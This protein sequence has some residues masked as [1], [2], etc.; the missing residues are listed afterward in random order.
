[1]TTKECCLWYICDINE[2]TVSQERIIK[3]LQELHD[4]TY[5]CLYSLQNALPTAELST[6]LILHIILKKLDTESYK[7][8]E[9]GLQNPKT[10]QELTPFLEFLSAR[11]VH[12]EAIEDNARREEPIKSETNS[13]SNK[14]NFDKKNYEKR[15]NWSKCSICDEEHETKNCKVFNQLTLQ[16]R[17][18]KVKSERICNNCLK[19]GQRAHKCPSKFTCATCQNKHHTLLH[20][21]KLEKTD[22]P[23]QVMNINLL[24]S[25][26]ER[27][28]VSKPKKAVILTTVMIAIRMSGYTYSLRALF[29]F[30]NKKY[31]EMFVSLVEKKIPRK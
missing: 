3:D 31:E 15:N 18:E 16:K 2:I 26:V 23:K 30:L 27:H 9:S 29:L 22:S 19:K 13:S 1:M 14:K 10:P 20:D 4:E 12:L 21:K 17:L 5:K 24:D 28:T 6:A 11:V 8:Y 7:E 25:K